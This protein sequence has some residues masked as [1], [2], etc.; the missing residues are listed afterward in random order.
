LTEQGA[1]PASGKTVNILIDLKELLPAGGKQVTFI[2]LIF[3][4]L[5]RINNPF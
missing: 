1:L 4:K 2:S 5:E 3:I